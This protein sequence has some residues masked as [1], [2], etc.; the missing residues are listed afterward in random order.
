MD[1]H[2]A[3]PSSSVCR[4]SAHSTCQ[5]LGALLTAVFSSKPSFIREESKPSDP[6][7]NENVHEARL[8]QH[9]IHR[10]SQLTK[11]DELKALIEQIVYRHSRTGG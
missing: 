3:G 2:F 6:F 9:N 5:Y 10:G 7:D 11:L 4:T 1:V 8:K